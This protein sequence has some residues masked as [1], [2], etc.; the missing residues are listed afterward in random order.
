M[1]VQRVADRMLE[2]GGGAWPVTAEQMR[3]CAER[4]GLT[5]VWH[6]AVPGVRAGRMVVVRRSGCEAGAL[7]RAVHEIAEHLAEGAGP[8]GAHGVAEQIERHY[9]AVLA[10]LPAGLT[11]APDAAPRPAC[12]RPASEAPEEGWGE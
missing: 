11:S 6:G 2:A 5:L 8:A 12:W 10:H 4:L 3:Q 1:L 9:R 7:A